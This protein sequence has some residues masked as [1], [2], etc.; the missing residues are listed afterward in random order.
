MPDDVVADDGRVD[1]WVG[2]ALAYTAT[3][4][5]KEPKPRTAKKAG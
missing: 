3:L 1:D 4:P 5:P 2:R